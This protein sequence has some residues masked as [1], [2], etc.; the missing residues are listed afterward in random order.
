[1][2]NVGEF[3][4]GFMFQR[5]N[6]WTGSMLPWTGRALSVHRGPMAAWTEGGARRGGA[7]TGARPSAAS[8][9]QSSPAGAQKGE[10]STGSSARASP[11]LRRR[12]SDRAT[13]VVRRSHGKLGGEGFWR[14]RGEEKD[15][16]RC[17]VLRGSSGWLL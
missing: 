1:L 2:Q 8:V 14:G 11:E 3:Q 17:G 9:H 6:P 15:A 13:A 16:V 4:P 12:R 7:L 10:R 5:I